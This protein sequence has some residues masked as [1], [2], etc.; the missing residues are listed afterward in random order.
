MNCSRYYISIFFLTVIYQLTITAQDIAYPR[1]I[2]ITLASEEMKGRG[3]VQ[4]GNRLAANYISN[5]FKKMGLLSYGKN[6]FQ[7]FTL[8][9]NT[10]PGSMSANINGIELKPGIDYLVDAESPGI[11]GTFQTLYINAEELLK[12]DVFLPKIKT[13]KDKLIVIKAYDK[14][15][16]NQDENKKIANAIYF[17]KTFPE[18]QF[19]GIILLTKNK[20]IWDVSDRRYSK[21]VLTIKTD[22]LSPPIEKITL[23]IK[24][25]YIKNFHT[26]NV[27][28][29]IEGKRKDSMIVLTAH[30]DHLGMMGKRTIFPGANDNASGVA[31]LLNLAKYYSKNKPEYTTVF[32]A[33]AGEEIG[34]IG[35][36]YFVSHPLFEL[37]TIKFLINFDLAGTGDEGIQVVNGSIFKN[38]FDKLS[39][40][41]EE[42]HF[43]PQVKIRGE[44]CNSDHCPFYKKDVPC[45]FIYTLG[46]I[47]AYH[48]VY[49]KAETFPF[50][51]FYEYFKLILAF[52]KD[53]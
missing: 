2:V 28:A 15:R 8:P 30:Y 27:I 36:E 3:Y 32:I 31:M 14:K 19:A 50:T 52:I 10:F 29:Y 40:I 34:L 25:K 39:K 9:V 18:N 17:L 44:A 16:Y 43:L 35:S 51:I 37:Q 5:E 49:D 11:E 23:N 41:N 45:F 53:L 1:K 13:A 48:D 26:Q 24:S 6:Y 42:Q 46:G 20:L 33:F 21:P 4:N 22:S 7:P 47:T 12:E 38:K